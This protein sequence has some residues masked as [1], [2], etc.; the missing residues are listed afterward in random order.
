MPALPPRHNPAEGFPKRFGF[1]HISQR[2]GS[3]SIAIRGKPIEMM[4][5]SAIFRH[6]SAKFG[7]RP[8][9]GG[10]ILQV[11]NSRISHEVRAFFKAL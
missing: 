8:A 7:L 3:K 5:C 1:S 2:T 6:C 9:A 10:S 4:R 11:R